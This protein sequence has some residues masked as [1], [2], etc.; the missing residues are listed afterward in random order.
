MS[1]FVPKTINSR[2]WCWCFSGKKI[3]T[4]VQHWWR[5]SPEIW[6]LYCWFEILIYWMLWIVKYFLVFITRV[7][8]TIW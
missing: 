6:S 7:M 1:I 3:N 5:C 8:Y 4:V 2:S